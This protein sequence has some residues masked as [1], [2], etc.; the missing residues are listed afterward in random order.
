MEALRLQWTPAFVLYCPLS[1]FE[2]TI[3]D[4]DQMF[5]YPLS[6]CLKVMSP[7]HCKRGPTLHLFCYL[8]DRNKQGRL[9]MWV[10]SI[11]WWLLGWVIVFVCW[12]FC[13]EWHDSSFIDSIKAT[14]KVTLVELENLKSGLWCC[15]WSQKGKSLNMIEDAWCSHQYNH[16]EESLNLEWIHLPFTFWSQQF[17]RLNLN[18]T[19]K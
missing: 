14:I 7:N 11:I 6:N 5:Q 9:G 10:S 16:N 8:N 15:W 3:M 4:H 19:L 12:L 18:S 1:Q 17:L 2:T 13:A